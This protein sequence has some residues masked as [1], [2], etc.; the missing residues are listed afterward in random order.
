MSE[1]GTNVCNSYMVSSCCMSCGHDTSQHLP[2]ISR[3][4]F[5][6]LMSTMC[7]ESC[8]GLQDFRLWLTTEPTDKFP[9]GI[10]Q[11]TLKVVTEPPNGLKLNMRSSYSKITDA[12]LASCPHQ[13]PHSVLSLNT[14]CNLPLLLLMHTRCALSLLAE[15]GTAGIVDDTVKGLTCWAQLSGHTCRQSWA[16]CRLSGHWC[17]YWLS[18]M[19]WCKRGVSMASWAGMCPMTSTRLTSESAWHSLLPISRR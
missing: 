9:I 2:C 11:R 1:E 17:G 16:A 8:D 12:L 3:P 13:V 10:L 19:Q 6:D 4:T 7:A 18:S 15:C 14:C 5:V